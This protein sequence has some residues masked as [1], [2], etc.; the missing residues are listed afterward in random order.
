[1]EDS[2]TLGARFAQH[3]CGAILDRAYFE[4]RQPAYLLEMAPFFD[5]LAVGPDFAL[6]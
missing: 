3:R 2:N 4:D 1:M 6:P 5:A